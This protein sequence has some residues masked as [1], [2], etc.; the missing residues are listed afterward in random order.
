MIQDIYVAA[1]V[2]SALGNFAGT[3]KDKP[4]T[5]LASEI[6]QSCIKRSGADAAEFDHLVFT[7]TCPTDKDSLFAARVV[8][9]KSG[10]PADAGALDVSRACASGLQA[11]LAA[12]R[13]WPQPSRNRCRC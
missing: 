2:R 1:G 6:V 9:M 8:G 13:D 11:I 10:L 4:M 3:L 5:E 12:N 7:A